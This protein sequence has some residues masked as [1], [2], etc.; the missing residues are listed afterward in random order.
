M[1]KIR[2]PRPCLECGTLTDGD[3]RCPTHQA[4]LDNQKN[5]IRNIRNN[6]KKKTLYG[7]AQY[8]K[9]AKIVRDTAVVCH[10][11]LGPGREGDPWQAD[12]IEAT[13]PNSQLASAHRSCNAKRGNMTVEEFRIKYNIPT[14]RRHNP[15]VGS[16]I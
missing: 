3:T 14:G 6:Q 11:C 12:H 15:G 8:R 4:K 16:N 9:L 7:G 10:L 2:I 5:A 13:N 1:A